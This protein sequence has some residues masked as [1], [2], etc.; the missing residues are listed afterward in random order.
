MAG[1]ARFV[2]GTLGCVACFSFAAPLAFMSP[3]M[4]VPQRPG[5]WIEP[6][7]IHD[8]VLNVSAAGVR[9]GDLVYYTVG[10]G[11]AQSLES[12]F[13]APSHPGTSPDA[14]FSFVVYAD[15]GTETEF[16]CLQCRIQ[17]KGSRGPGAAATVSRVV[18]QELEKHL[19]GG[20]APPP[21]FVLHV[22]DLSYARNVAFKWYV[23][24]RAC[25]QARL[26]ACDTRPWA[27]SERVSE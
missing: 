3:F 15:M 11:A 25:V 21:A 4:H 24:G 16:G 20:S 7:W 27:A 1:H 14:P 5:T 10:S 6:G 22:G 17:E 26:R 18:S 23:P 8:V 13:A 2:G 9:P 12:S 19:L